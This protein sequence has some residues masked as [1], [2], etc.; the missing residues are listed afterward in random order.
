[1]TTDNIEGPARAVES[2]ITTDVGGRETIEPIVQALQNNGE[3]D[4]Q[5]PPALAAAKLLA[6]RV[7]PGDTVVVLTG[8]PI[9]PTM[10]PETDGPPGAV[11][12]AS[13]VDGGLSGNVIIA[14]DPGAVDICAATARA[15]GLSVLPRA[16]SLES[17][18]TVAV[19]PFPTDHSDAV[20]YADDLTAL[21]P[22]AVVAIEKVGPNAEGVYH[23]MAGYD[24]SGATAEVS[25]LYDRLDD[26]VT[27]SVGDAGNEVGMGVVEE[28]V[29]S[30]IDYGDECQ[31]DCGGGIACAI[32]T[33]LLVPSAVSNWGAHG[34][35]TCL[36]AVLDESLLHDPEIER[37]MLVEGSL[38]GAIDG[39]S[40]GTNAWCD[41]LPT[42][43]HEATVRLL[44][45]I[46]GSSV[47]NRGGGELAR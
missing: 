32:E 16:E 20:S 18:G 14:C 40:G 28:A 11:S 17:A 21:D 23:N 34:V 7:D 22:A 36:S 41:G 27:I 3:G 38:A 35:V 46:P 6:E 31:C 24:V 25:P 15:G 37:R 2:L 30:E 44:K 5:E 33:D 10:V 12:I 47:H 42:D 26:A 1:M 29:R 19:E 39:I 9:P 13:A 4:P 8:F 43:V 45:E